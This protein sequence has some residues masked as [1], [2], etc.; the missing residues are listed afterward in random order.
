MPTTTCGWCHHQS[1]QASLIHFSTCHHPDSE[2]HLS[3]CNSADGDCSSGSL[4]PHPHPSISADLV[5][6]EL[7]SSPEE[8]LIFELRRPISTTFSIA[9]SSDQSF[10]ENDPTTR[11][12]AKY[13][14]ED[15]FTQVQKCAGRRDIATWSE[16]SK[17][18]LIDAYLHH[19]ENPWTSEDLVVCPARIPFPGEASFR[20]DTLEPATTPARGPVTPERRNEINQTRQANRERRRLAELESNVNIS[21]HRPDSEFPRTA[22]SQSVRPASTQ[23]LQPHGSPSPRR[24][25]PRSA[26]PRSLEIPHPT[27]TRITKRQGRAEFP[28]AGIFGSEQYTRMPVMLG[29]RATG[30]REIYGSTA[31]LNQGSSSTS[32]SSQ[33]MGHTRSYGVHNQQV[34]LES[35]VNS[36]S[37]GPEI[38]AGDHPPAEIDGSAVLEAVSWEGD[39]FEVPPAPNNVAFPAFR[40]NGPDGSP[41]LL[42]PGMAPIHHHSTYGMI[43]P[44]YP[45]FYSAVPP[46][47]QQTPD[48]FL[49]HD[50]NFDIHYDYT[51]FGFVPQT[52]PPDSQDFGYGPTAYPHYTARFENQGSNQRY[53]LMDAEPRM[54]SN[55][56]TGIFS[57]PITNVTIASASNLHTDGSFLDLPT[58]E[59][60]G[61]SYWSEAR[62]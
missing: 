47:G 38:H 20:L 40:V 39:S 60:L 52:S 33:E 49:P 61:N 11:F 24:R 9:S 8:I 21:E 19:P 41:N 42:H 29:D 10:D 5:A 55:Y 30:Q 59:S 25:R 13:G 34:E 14:Q 35:S 51:A 23:Q 48:H 3:E 37:W 36:V 28:A 46:P 7:A 50:S 16:S 57:S 18:S 31:Q 6:E 45:P 54:Q 44:E 53:P 26:N 12:R 43:P 4:H 62:F 22:R 56:N 32:I 17:L 15:I 27:T 1:F 58:E 2:D